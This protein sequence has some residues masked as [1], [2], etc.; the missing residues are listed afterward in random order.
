MTKKQRLMLG[1]T[2]LVLTLAITVWV[3]A[4]DTQPKETD[5]S[6]WTLVNEY[7]WLRNLKQECA[8]NLGIKDSAKFLKWYTWY[9]DS[10]DE[11]IIN[12]RNQINT[13]SHKDYEGLR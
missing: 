6:I 11:E 3:F 1:S 4:K 7:D 2:V 8:D 13:L 5:K 12:L 10:W 9:C